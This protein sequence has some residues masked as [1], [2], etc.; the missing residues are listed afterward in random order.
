MHQIACVQCC[1]AWKNLAANISYVLETL[2]KLEHLD[3]V[4]F[5]ELATTGYVFE[6]PQEI[7][8]FAR[9][10]HDPIWLPFQ[11]MAQKKDMGIVIGAPIQENQQIYNSALIFLPNG[12]AHAYHKIHLFDHEKELFAPGY[13][14]PCIYE[15]HGLYFSVLICFDWTFPE[16]WR[17]L[18]FQGADLIALPANLLLPDKCQKGI[19][20]HALYNRIF[21]AMANRYGIEGT[22]RFTGN[23]RMVGPD[24]EIV[25][26]APA[27]GD[28]IIF[29]HIAVQSARNKQI[30][31]HNHLFHDRRPEMYG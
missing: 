31:T 13:R 20:G 5:P 11:T 25:A 2:E 24:G 16:L 19:V 7:L 14:K 22:I 6:K 8:E 29:G 12:Q 17:S 1:P 23:S 30:T 18:A 28:R 4:I 10:I 3:L 27:I 9:T 15:V 21:V 26:E